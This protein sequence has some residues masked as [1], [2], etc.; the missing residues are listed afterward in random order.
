MYQYHELG[1]HAQLCLLFR[2]HHSLQRM[3]QP[4]R[5]VWL[6]QADITQFL[7]IA[8][9]SQF[10]L[11]TTQ[12][13]SCNTHWRKNTSTIMHLR[14]TSTICRSWQQAHRSCLTQQRRHCAGYAAGRWTLRQQHV[15]PSSGRYGGAPL[16][17]APSPKPCCPPS[18]PELPASTHKLSKSAFSCSNGYHGCHAVGA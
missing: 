16:H 13:A 18:K 8:T 17:P 4:S 11:G 7:R 2:Q 10:S 5:T 15:Q 6:E 14:N 3:W 1:N 12:G 9:G